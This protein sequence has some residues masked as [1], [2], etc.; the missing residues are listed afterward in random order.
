MGGSQ[1]DLP[2]VR[3]HDPAVQ[4]RQQPRRRSP[5]K[6]YPMI[7]KLLGQVAKVQATSRHGHL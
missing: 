2:D 3:L 6:H 1:A 7:G 4:H 5:P